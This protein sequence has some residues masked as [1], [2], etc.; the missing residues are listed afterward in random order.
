V[1]SSEGDAEQGRG[2]QILAAV[3]AGGSVLLQFCLTM[4]GSSPNATAS[5]WGTRLL[6]F[7]GYFTIESNLL[8]FASTLRLA[9]GRDLTTLVWRAVRLA[10]I[11]GIAVT[12]MVY[13]VALR[14][15]N[16]DQGWWAVANYGLHYVS[17]VVALVGWVVA[18]PRHRI[19]RRVLMVTVGWPVAWFGWVLTYGAI[20]DYYPYPFV[21]VAEVG[22]GRALVNALIVSALLVAVAAAAYGVDRW[23]GA[24]EPAAFPR[25]RTRLSKP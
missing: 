17:P 3:V 14:S 24:R 18:G 12:G 16:T 2:W 4:W 25:R 21:D 8:V 10:G 1:H 7:I 11:T 13:L 19:D 23:L 6:R 20:S 5:P 9:L 22:Y 15:Q